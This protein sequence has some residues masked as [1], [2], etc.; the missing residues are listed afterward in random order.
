MHVVT[1]IF[2]SLTGASPGWLLLGTLLHLANQLARAQGWH[3]IIADAG[4]APRRRDSTAAW[5]AGAG[6]GGVLSAR[7]GDAVR[8]LVLGPR[9]PETGA[10]VLTGTIVAEAAGDTLVGALVLVL[11]VVLGAAPALG[12]PGLTV[13]LW[14]GGALALACVAVIVARRLRPRRAAG[15]GRLRTFLSGVAR[16][17]APLTHPLRFGGR[18]LPWQVTSRLLRGGAVICFLAAYHLPAT[19]AAALLV[20]LAQSGGRL[21]PLA[22]ASVGASVAMLAAGF[23]PATGATASAT[24]LA[25]FLLG[26]STILTVIGAVATVAIIGPRA[27]AAACRLRRRPAAASPAG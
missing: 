15:S 18:V 24:S 17:C 16:G 2:D 3:A 14:V 23:G 7:A 20:M 22:P 5:V 1:G 25:A 21:L 11:A 6:A 8:I 13:A 12:L 19:P 9:A 10:S 27:A 4:N 26:M